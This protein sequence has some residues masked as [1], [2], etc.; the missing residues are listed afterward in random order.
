[1]T[2]LAVLTGMRRSEPVNLRW[3]DVDL[4]RKVVQVE[5]TASFKT[6]AGT[7]RTIPLSDAALVILRSR[8]GSSKS[9]WVFT[10]R[11]VK[12]DSQHVTHQFKIYVRTFG[13]RFS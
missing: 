9:E 5:S 10:D 7:R 2:L 3:A 12:I 11:G 8:E 6:K 4:E 13:L 1:M